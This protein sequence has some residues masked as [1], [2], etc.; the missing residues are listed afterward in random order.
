MANITAADV[1]KLRKQTGA[2]MMDCKKALVEAEGDFEKAIEVLRKKG[3]KVASKRADRE[4][5]EGIVI[6]K[7][8]EDN[9]FGAVIMV[10]CETDFVAMNEDFIAYANRLI[11]IAIAGKITS[12]EALKEAEI[13]GLK[14]GDS[15]IS[16]VGKIGEKIDVAHLQTIEDAFVA[17]YNHNG[18]RLATIVGLNKA[19]VEGIDVTGRDVAMQ[20]ASMAPLAVDQD[21][22]S[23]DTI[24]KELEI[25]KDLLR[26]EGKPEQMIEKISVGKMNKF[27]KDNTLINQEFIKE[28]KVIVKDY[29]AR[30]DKDLKVTSFKRVMLGA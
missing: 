10:N 11:D 28:S 29:V 13:D 20:V 4:A 24:E 8:S 9:S 15:L 26:Q 17:G 2:G 23:Q 5:N 7:V 19:G 3:Q 22:I 14:I 30:N 18:N 12:I 21:G 16:M 1:N 27:F 25:A 6:A